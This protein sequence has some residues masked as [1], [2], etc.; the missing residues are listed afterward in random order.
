MVTVVEEVMVAVV[1]DMEAKVVDMGV[2]EETMVATMK[3]LWVEVTAMW[4]II[5]GSNNQRRSGGAYGGGY[6]SVVDAVTEG[7]ENSRKG[8]SS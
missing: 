5:T 4:E 7:F 3:E 6:G 8:Y 1:Q 2:K